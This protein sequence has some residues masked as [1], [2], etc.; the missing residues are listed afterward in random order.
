MTK[1]IW[2]RPSCFGYALYVVAPCDN[3]RPLLVHI[4]GA[5][6]FLAYFRA[7]EQVCVKVSNRPLIVI[8]GSF[9]MPFCTCTNL[10]EGMLAEQRRR[11]RRSICNGWDPGQEH[12][13]FCR[14]GLNSV[15]Q[16]SG[17]NFITLTDEF[18]RYPR[19]ERR[20]Y[21]LNS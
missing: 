12:D 4:R 20:F 16:Y 8:F 6:E 7:L 9:H 17:S 21:W 15:Q 14:H 10:R 19:L 5:K 11:C 3:P 18:E 1:I 13:N 2:C